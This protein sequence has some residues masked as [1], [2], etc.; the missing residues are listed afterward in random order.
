[1]KL[2]IETLLREYGA[3][4]KKFDRGSVIYSSESGVEGIYYL[5]S[6]KIRIDNS[7]V[8][9]KKEVLIWLLGSGSFFGI[10]SYYNGYEACSYI[11]TVISESATILLISREEFIHLLK[12]HKIM[13]DF[14]ISLL[15]RRLDYIEQRRS[16]GPRVSFRKKLIDALVFLCPSH[17]PP[18][19]AFTGKPFKI[20]VTLTELCSMISTTRKQLV[21]EIDNLINKRIIERD[22]DGITVRNY[23][24]LMELE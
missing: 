1:M 20:A 15:Y 17:R 11:T 9:D 16:Y 13:R 21:T 8:R 3:R 24:K 6:G 12:E 2:E 19:E 18:E 10:S 5:V 23:P 7:R 4:E 22:G 14:I